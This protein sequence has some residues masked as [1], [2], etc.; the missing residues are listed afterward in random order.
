MQLAALDADVHVTSMRRIRAAGSLAR[1]SRLAPDEGSQPG[2]V[3]HTAVGWRVA[4]QTARR[5]R[6]PNASS[7]AG[8]QE[9]GYR[10]RSRPPANRFV[11]VCAPGAQVCARAWALARVRRAVQQD[12]RRSASL[13]GITPRHRVIRKEVLADGKK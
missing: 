5:A 10:H 1:R 11:P 8:P 6:T 7:H 12:R 2:A 4:R 9:L 13:C 3:K